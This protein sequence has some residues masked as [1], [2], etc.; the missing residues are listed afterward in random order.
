MTNEHFISCICFSRRGLAALKIA[1][2]CFSSQTYARKELIIL[3]DGPGCA[4]PEWNLLNGIENITIIRN[5]SRSFEST[6][7][8]LSTIIKGEYVMIWNE[9]D[10]HH[11]KRLEIQLNELLQNGKYASGLPYFLIYNRSDNRSY[12]SFPLI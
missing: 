6:K 4:D 2:E 11:K 10:W 8:L 3:A 5:L 9:S 1:I 12:L 7:E